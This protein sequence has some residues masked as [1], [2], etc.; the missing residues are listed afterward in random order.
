MAQPTRDIRVIP[1]HVYEHLGDGIVCHGCNEHH[2]YEEAVIVLFGP[3]GNT[4]GGVALCPGCRI[5]TEALLRGA[6]K[7]ARR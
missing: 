2:P 6:R 4:R 3:E 7:G 1:G 5:K